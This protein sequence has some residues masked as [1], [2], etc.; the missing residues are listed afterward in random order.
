MQT[1]LRALRGFMRQSQEQHARGADFQDLAL[2]HQHAAISLETRAQV[3]HSKMS[4]SLPASHVAA[5]GH[6]V[7][8][9]ALR[10]NLAAVF[11]MVAPLVMRRA[12]LPA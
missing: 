6:T 9:G 7:I 4:M 11:R 2:L 3:A 10:A 5:W 1:A 12:G 8:Q